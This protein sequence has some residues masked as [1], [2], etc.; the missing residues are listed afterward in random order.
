VAPLPKSP[1]HRLARLAGT[2]FV[3][4]V[5]GAFLWIQLPRPPLPAARYLEHKG[6][7]HGVEVLDRTRTETGLEEEIQLTSTTGL[8]VRGRLV[9]PEPGGPPRPAF[10]VMGGL[11]AGRRALEGLPTG[12]FPVVWLALDYPYRPPAAWPRVPNLLHELDRAA[13][14]AERSVAAALLALEY[15]ESRSDVDPARTG[16]AGGSLGA[17]VAVIA[18]AV[19]AHPDAVLVLNGG[20][21]LPRILRANLK[22]APWVA[23]VL[24][25]LL[26]RPWLSRVDP[27][28]YAPRIAPRPLLMVNARDDPRMPEVCVQALYDAAGEPKQLVRLNVPHEVR[29]RPAA[30]EPVA[31]AVRNW[32][33]GLGWVEAP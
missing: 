22:R 1:R 14:S 3:A 27:V 28:G 10:V 21:D 24:L 33:E 19:D 17:F 11:A 5:L 20:G 31:R 8:Q 30:A 2:A 13:A 7:L 32:L 29:G 15:L 23:R 4:L 26:A 6:T 9:G 12:E 25:P 18:G 16:M